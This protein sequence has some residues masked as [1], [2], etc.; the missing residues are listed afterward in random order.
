MAGTAEPGDAVFDF[1]SFEFA[2]VAFVGVA[3]ARNEMVAGEQ[4]DTETRR[5]QSS[6]VWASCVIGCWYIN[7]RNAMNGLALTNKSAILV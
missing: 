7:G 1:F 6:Q 2:F 4:G 3:G 5:P